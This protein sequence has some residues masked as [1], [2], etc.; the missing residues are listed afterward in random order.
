MSKLKG[1]FKLDKKKRAEKNAA[2]RGAGMTS[3]HQHKAGRETL[4]LLALCILCVIHAHPKNNNTLASPCADQLISKGKGGAAAPK[5]A[6]AG[7]AVRDTAAI[8][9]ACIS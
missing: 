5:G 2:A 7:G 1:T 8:M 4:V 9:H 3:H 6:P